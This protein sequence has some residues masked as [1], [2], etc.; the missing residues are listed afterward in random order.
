[1]PARRRLAVAA[2]Q[3]AE[4][5]P[6]HLFQITLGLKDARPTDWSGQAV[7]DGGEV[8]DLKGWRFQ[9]KD[10]VEGRAW[11]CRTRIAIAPLAR[12]PLTPAD[13]KAPQAPQRPWPNGVLL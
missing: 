10:A 12:Y 13:G 4:A 5:P 8:A 1:M 9:P 2:S 3:S 7:V 6:R 11:K